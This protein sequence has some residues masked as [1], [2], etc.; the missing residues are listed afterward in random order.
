MTDHDIIIEALAKEL[1]AHSI[2]VRYF[3]WGNDQL[4]W[5]QWQWHN[6]WGRP[7]HS[8]SVA[9]GNGTIYLNHTNAKKATN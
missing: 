7:Q 9:I 4:D 2:Y 8:V 1:G 3:R 5:Y 6:N